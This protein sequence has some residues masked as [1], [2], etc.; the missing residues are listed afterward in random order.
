MERVLTALSGTGSKESDFQICY[1]IIAS[2][3]CS[4]KIII[5]FSDYDDL[6]YYAKQLK[7]KF[8]EATS[9][10]ASTCIN[11]CTDGYSEKGLSVMAI[12][13]GVECSSGLIYEVSRHPKNYSQHIREALKSLTSTDNTCCLEFTTSGF[14]CEELVLDTF[15][16]VLKGTG[17]KVAGSTAGSNK[18]EKTSLVALNGDIYIESCSFIFIH[19]LEGKVQLYRENLF[20]PTAH[21]L[22]ITD[23]DCEQQRVYE[24]ENKPAA[25]VLCNL[26]NADKANLLPVLKTNPIG[27]IEG[28]NILISEAKEVMPDDSIIYYTR[29]YN[30]TRVVLLEIDNFDS[31]WDET[32]KHMKKLLPNPSFT[33]AVH[34]LSRTKLLKQA[35]RFDDF[36]KRLSTLLGKY[37]GVSGYG[38]QIMYN[39]LNQSL[40]LIS[41]E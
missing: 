37:I 32:A 30:M 14:R 34:C 20:R 35:N 31:V 26:L 16:D 15:E 27:R 23:V 38:E 2:Q 17:I 11:F 19:N 18:D 24:F 28:D 3:N 1:D 10:G 21:Q 25:E 12:Y 22:R 36:S 33:I 39:N 41:F 4:P 9:I 5:F 29:L 13:S 8:P 6:W 40:V 7:E